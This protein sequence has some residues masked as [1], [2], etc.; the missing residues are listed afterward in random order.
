MNQTDSTPTPSQPVLV[1]ADGD[2]SAPGAAIVP[3]RD[4]SHEERRSLDKSLAKGVAWMGSIRWLTQ[5]LTWASTL[6]VVRLLTPADYGLVGLA[7]MY[8][9]IVTMLSEF[10]IG[11]TIVALRDLTEDDHAQINALSMLFGFASFLVSCAVA[12]LLA[13]FFN[14]PELTMVVIAM[15]TIFIITGARVVPQAILQR[16]MRFRDLALNDGLQ[17]VALAVG[18]VVFAFFGFRYWTLVLSAILGAL[19]S[20]IGVL[21]LV[22]VPFKRPQWATLRPAV[23][24]SQQTIFARLAWYVYQ[25]AD[26]FV[27]GKVFGKD[28]MGVYRVAWDLTS[29]PLE[30]I[31]S[32]VGR[33]TP[34]VLSA[35]QNDKAALR[36]Y[37]LRI[38]EVLALV[39]FPATIGLGLIAQ[40]LV[41]LVFGRQWAGMVVPLQLLSIA[42]SIRAIAPILPQ[43]LTVTGQN[44]RGMQINL[45]GAF[46]MPVAFYIGSRWGTT[47]IAAMW[48]L[49]Y[50]IALVIPDGERR[51][52]AGGVAVARVPARPRCAAERCGGDGARRLGSAL[53]DAAG[54]VARR[55]PDAAGE[56]RGARVWRVA[57]HLPPGARARPH[58]RRARRARLTRGARPHVVRLTAPVLHGSRCSGTAPFAARLGGLPAECGNRRAALAEDRRVG[59][60]ARLDHRRDPAGSRGS[61]AARRAAAG[62]RPARCTA[63]RRPLARGGPPAR[64][65]RGAADAARRIG[66]ERGRRSVRRNAG[67]ALARRRRTR[68]RGATRT[69]GA[70]AARL[71]RPRLLRPVERLGDAGGRRRDRAGEG[72]PDTRRS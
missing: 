4:A 2:A 41:P 39:T 34:S 62:G 67:R 50:P 70:R 56:G 71:S 63:V 21:R 9:G 35:A 13:S 43:V 44:R 3:P 5:L 19:L 17:A 51:L 10:G 57:A 8:L 20:T 33:V 68:A 29:T 54:V 26:F 15:S 22:R 16:D 14:A 48:I 61:V 18:A 7:S 42:A 25:N 23:A 36:R 65:E 24:F 47:G 6:I 72:G 58:R 28:L 11:T 32:M 52:S 53:G 66:R 49:V 59:A 69:R 55:A 27:A 1:V 31:V 60:G 46:V 64:G 37:V 40:D 30:K 12:P 45:V 38:T